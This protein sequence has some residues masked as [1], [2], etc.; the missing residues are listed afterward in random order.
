VASGKRRTSERRAQKLNANTAKLLIGV[1][2]L[3]AEG[4]S[5][6]DLSMDEITQA[7]GV[8]RSTLYYYYRDKAELLLAISETAI[9][10]IEE[11]S[12]G[13]GELDPNLSRAEFV[14]TV[15]DALNTWRPHV[16]ITTALAELAAYNPDV[17][18]RFRA[19]WG[20]I[21]HRIIEHIKEGQAA[22]RIRKRLKPADTAAWLVWMLERGMSQ[23]IGREQ[24]DKRIKQL[25][26][27]AA[28]ILYTTLYDAQPRAAARSRRTAASR[29]EP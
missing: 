29:V 2:T 11:A 13:V 10:Q 12:R 23:A 24:D 3:L 5:F 18:S 20:V 6:T 22:G 7:A 26:D 9:A 19:A 27:A 25:I 17:E 14:K 4:N 28:E 16:P 8:P 1:E 21:E 15:R